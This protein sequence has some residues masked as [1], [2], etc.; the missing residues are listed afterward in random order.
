MK[1]ENKTLTKTELHMMNLLWDKGTASVQQL[2]DELDEP[3][4]P[5]T[6]TL[7]VMQVLTKKGIVA[8][9]KDGRTNIYRPLL[10]RE[11]YLDSFVNDTKE[12]LF[13]GSAVSLFSFFAKKEKL[14]KH[15][16]QAIL[17]EMS[18]E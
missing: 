16:V 11:E 1:K 3:K 13:G 17:R 15:E 9:D 18:E 5:Y 7:S 6:T 4:P 12:T 8:Y 14:S 10:S 2:H